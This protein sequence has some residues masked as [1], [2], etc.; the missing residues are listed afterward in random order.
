VRLPCLPLRVLEEEEEEEEEAVNNKLTT[1]NTNNNHN[2]FTAPAAARF[3]NTAVRTILS[4]VHVT[5]TR[6]ILR[7]AVGRS[8]GS[9]LA[10]P[11]HVLGLRSH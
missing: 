8:V 6:A 9:I 2:H 11:H 7:R 4:A 3:A 1:T 5:R 10:A